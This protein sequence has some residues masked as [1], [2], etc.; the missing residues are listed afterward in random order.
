MAISAGLKELNYAA[1][2]MNLQED[3][4]ECWMMNMLTTSTTTIYL[5][6]VEKSAR[7]PAAEL[8]DMT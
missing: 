5:L 3:D 2:M 8:T 4:V 7:S 6:L 1:E